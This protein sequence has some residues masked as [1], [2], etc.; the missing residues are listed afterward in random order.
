MS[1]RIGPQGKNMKSLTPGSSRQQA[2]EAVAR[3]NEQAFLD[4]DRSTGTLKTKLTTLTATAV[5]QIILQL[6]PTVNKDGIGVQT[7]FTK[8]I[9]MFKNYDY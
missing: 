3:A 2:R 4:K 9:G 5:G 1:G 6:D 7:E 8:S